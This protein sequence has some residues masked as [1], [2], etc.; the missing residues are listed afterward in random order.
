MDTF[1]HYAMG[2]A[3]FAMEDSGGPPIT[4][5]NRGAV[6]VVVGS[7][8]GGLPLIEETQQATT[9]RTAATRGSSRPSSSRG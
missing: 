5:E 6:G 2:A 4:D 1:I 8:I 9:S 7:G 3:H